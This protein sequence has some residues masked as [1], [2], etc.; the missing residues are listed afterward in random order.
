M[1]K[2]FGTDGVRGVAGEPPLDPE[3][4][5]RLG[6]ALI[7]QLRAQLP[8][9]ARR[10]VPVRVCLGQD[11][12]ES[13][14]WITGCLAQGVRDAGGEPV[15]AG[16]LPTPGLALIVR[17]GHFD[18][19]LMVSAS[20]NAYTDNGVKIFDAYGVKLPDEQEARIEQA[21]DAAPAPTADIGALPVA[22]DHSLARLY[23]AALDRCRDN[24][25]FTG[26][27]IVLDTAHGAAYQLAPEAF[28]RAGA[29]V[30]V[31][32]DRPD[33]RNINDGVGS[34]HPDVMSRAV[35]EHGAHLGFSFDGDADRCI[36]ASSTGKIL[37]G[38]FVLYY[39]GRVL[40]RSGRLPHSTVVSTVMSNLGLEKAL[41]LEG[42]RMTRTAVGDRYV[43]EELKRSGCILGGEQSG[44]LIFMDHA[45]TGDGLQSAVL[46]T[47][48]WREGA[49]D[50]DE[51]LAQI[52]HFPQV[53]HNIRVSSKPAI[54]E[55][56]AL[57]EAVLRAERSLGGD[58][59]VIVRYSGTEPK[60]RVMIEGP[61]SELVERLAV[62]VAAVFER[63]IGA[64]IGL[65]TP[66]PS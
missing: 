13:C 26:L 3:T 34:L 29:E 12:R 63:E 36:A 60:A 11:T 42:I 31:I 35:L 64:P 14:A 48:W 10:G 39:A 6:F 19:G 38:D 5:C 49:G 32:G 54:E 9:R 17:E 62:E 51:A 4:L 65:E 27:K 18:A 57:R 47:R 22:S 2:L 61:D 15:S 56:P 16:V 23:L 28:R 50:L 37:D 1:R 44:H 25:S 24:A 58:G 33:G 66:D 40:Q 7:A 21:M 55:H 46:L 53:L 45:P 30:V 41:A 52:P 43:L 8:D 59:R 20:H